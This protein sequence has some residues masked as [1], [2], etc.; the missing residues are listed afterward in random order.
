MKTLSYQMKSFSGFIYTFKEANETSLSRMSY[1]FKKNTYRQQA[2]THLVSSILQE[3]K[4][5]AWK[6]IL[7]SLKNQL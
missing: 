4:V 2:K 7:Y 6:T 5:K 3:N 1:N